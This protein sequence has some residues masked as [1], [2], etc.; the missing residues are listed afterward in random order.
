MVRLVLGIVAG[1]VTG[2]IVISLMEMIGHAIW[3]PVAGMDAGD[4]DAV[5]ASIAAMPPTALGFIVAGWTAGAFVGAL[6]ANLIARRA[7]AGWIIAGLVVVSIIANAAM[8][9]APIWMPASG[10]VLAL[11]AGWI[12]SRIRPMPF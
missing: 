6:V 7:L 12:A 10:I 3:P 9:P 5:R 1:I 2:M 11:L 8:I 4:M